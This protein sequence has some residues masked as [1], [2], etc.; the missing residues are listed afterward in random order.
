MAL[1]EEMGI[2]PRPLRPEERELLESVLPEGRPGYSAYR[3]FLKAAVV[4]GEGRRGKGNLVLGPEGQEPDVASPLGQVVAYG[5]LETTLD[6]YSITVREC[7]GGQLDVEIVSRRGEEIPEHFEEKYRWTYSSWSPGL[8][9]P[10]SGARVREVRITD[11]ATLAIAPNEGRL[12]VHE[13]ATGINHLIPIT[14]FYNQLVL[15]KNIRD[16][17]V[18]LA[19][20][21]FFQDEGSYTDQ[22]L[23]AAFI[24]Y[25]KLKPKVS[26]SSVPPRSRPTRLQ[27]LRA[28]LFRRGVH[29]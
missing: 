23:R 4:L 13:G 18:A 2:Y 10:A 22:E 9:S 8:P 15:Y 28:K 27:N 25:N 21:R 17:K 11:T 26:V 19:S 7:T 24:E 3:E 14:N 16:P 12:W 20:D 29:E 6:Q 1:T 5:M